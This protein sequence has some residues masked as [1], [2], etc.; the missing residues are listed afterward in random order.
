MTKTRHR[1]GGL[2]KVCGCPRRQW[3]KC[4]HSWYLNYKPRRGPSYRLSLDAHMGKHIA[5]KTEAAKL[6]NGIKAAI[7]AGTFKTRREAAA[8][9]ARA[10]EAPTT[11]D[12]VTLKAF[13]QTYFER[14]GKPA[15]A[16]DKSCLARLVAFNPEGQR[17]LGETPLAAITEDQLEL[18]FAQLRQ[19][20]RAAS[21]RNKYVQLVKALFRWATKKGYLA[22]NPVADSESIKREKHA[23]RSRRLA[24]D[25]LDDKGN[26]TREGEERRLLAVTGLHLKRLIIAALDT[27]M[28]RGEL[29]ALQW[30]DVDLQRRELTVRAENT[31]TRKTRHLRISSRLAGVLEMALAAL[32]TLLSTT[33]VGRLSEQERAAHVARCYVFGDETGGKVTNIKRAWETAVLKAHGHAPEWAEWNKLAPGSRAA[34]R[35][36]DLHFHDLRH[37]AGSRLLEGGVPLHDVQAVLGHENLSQTSTYLNATR[38]GVHE[39]MRRFDDARCKSVAQNTGTEHPPLCNADLLMGANSLVN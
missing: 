16:N 19:E 33:E 35:T 8:D 18:F 26:V 13:G 37:E 20:G 1:N 9:A 34:L 39:S 24:P 25:L 6:A 30:R 28:R 38:L 21:T 14:R 11:P 12:A 5:G 32:E 10:Q 22:R 15:T 23:K 29:L 31:K 3:P 27:G 7:D 17:P 36:I 2:R 4:A